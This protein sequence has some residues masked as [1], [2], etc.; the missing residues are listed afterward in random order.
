MGDRVNKVIT[1]ELGESIHINFDMVRFSIIQKLNINLARVII[2]N[3]REAQEIA[4]FIQQNNLS[5]Q[6][7]QTEKKLLENVE[8]R[9]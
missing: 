4:D 3:P 5:Y 9:G 7:E 6:D 2:L 1:S 8:R